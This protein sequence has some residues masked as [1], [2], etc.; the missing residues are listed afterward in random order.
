M[1]K[2]TVEGTDNY[3]KI[4]YIHDSIIKRVNYDL[5]APYYDT[6]LGFFIEPY[7]IVCEG[8]SKAM[9][10]LCD[11]ENIPCILVVGNI[12]LETNFAHMW[13]YVQ[14]EDGQWYAVD[15]TWDDLDDETNPVKYQYF[16]KGS[17]S[18]NSNH[19]PDNTYITPAFTYPEL[20]DTDYVYISDQPIVTTSVTP[21][22]TSSV[23]TVSISVESF[24]VSK[25]T[26]TS[27]SNVTLTTSAVSSVAL[28]TSS[29]GTEVV[30]KGDFNNNGKLD[31]GDAVI[32]QRKLVR[33]LEISDTDLNYE[34][35][36]DK[37]LN[38]WDYVILL[39]R[40]RSI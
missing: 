5:S 19:T 38:I 9:K 10:I 18:F 22:V 12:N 28:T 21:Q 33:S 29:S 17:E 23:T 32:L 2:F 16:L 35:N 40:I 30:I 15:C 39:R 14:M 13:N 31:T 4:K 26:V 24:A 37:R 6:A 27:E 3:S 36:D 34:L 20:S 1:D 7:G 25:T 11:K 8:Y